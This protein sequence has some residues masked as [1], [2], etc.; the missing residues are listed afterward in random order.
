MI[1]V[2]FFPFL[3]HLTAIAFNGGEG[4]RRRS[5]CNTTASEEHHVSHCVPTVRQL[6]TVVFNNPT[7]LSIYI[8]LA[9]LS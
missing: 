3:I 2:V 5:H 8:S 7:F 9:M 6:K 4:N 1:S